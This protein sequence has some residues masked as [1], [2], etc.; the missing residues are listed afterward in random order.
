MDVYLKAAQMIEER[1]DY[2]CCVLSRLGVSPYRFRQKFCPEGR[3]AHAFWLY[4]QL[5]RREYKSFRVLALCLM[6]AIVSYRKPKRR[7]P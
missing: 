5:S 4:G 1:N 2:S 7:K 6:S 3:E